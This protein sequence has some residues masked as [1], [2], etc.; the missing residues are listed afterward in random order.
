MPQSLYLLHAHIIFSTKHRRPVLD[1]EH[2]FKLYAYMTGILRNLECHSITIGGIEDH[3]HIGCVITKKYAPMKVLEWL[4]KDSSKW[5]K[6]LSPKFNDFHW[7]DGYGLFSISP[8]HVKPLRKYIMNQ[9]EHHKT[10]T[11]QEEFIRL[12]KKSDVEYNERYLW[13]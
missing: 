5:L 10:E 1:D 9:V 2:R 7:Q 4:K 3:V 8:S 12:L 13:D 6:T 11:F